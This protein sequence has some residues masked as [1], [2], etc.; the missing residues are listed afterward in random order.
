L[1]ATNPFQTLII[2]IGNPF[3][4]DDGVGLAVIRRLEEQYVLPEGVQTIQHIGECTH[5]MDLWEHKDKTILIDAAHQGG[6]PGTVYRFNVTETWT[7]LYQS[8]PKHSSHSFGV[9]EAIALARAINRLPQQ[10]VVFAME[11]AVFDYGASLSIEVTRAIDSL[12]KQVF[13]ECK[14]LV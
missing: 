6:Q 5:L 1:I 11:V 7:E 13:R 2:G 10:L 14:N 4:G 3:R 8:L 9:A 12:V